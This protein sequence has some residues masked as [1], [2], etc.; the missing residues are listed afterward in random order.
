MPN[1]LVNEEKQVSCRLPKSLV[2]RVEEKAKN[3]VPYI[4]VP[5]VEVKRILTEFY[6]KLDRELA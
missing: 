4:I 3:A 6:E 5:A 2:E 1:K